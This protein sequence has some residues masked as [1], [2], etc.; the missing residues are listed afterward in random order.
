MNALMDHHP[1]VVVAVVVGLALAWLTLIVC[2]PLD[3]EQVESLDPWPPEPRDPVR[4]VRL[5][6]G[7]SVYDWAL[8]EEWKHFW[9]ADDGL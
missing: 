7:S 6:I 1:A 8:D 9:L 5:L 2:I 4:N 3:D